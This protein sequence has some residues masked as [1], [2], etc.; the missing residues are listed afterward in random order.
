MEGTFVGV[1]VGGGF[2]TMDIVLAV[3]CVPP[4][5]VEVN[6]ID[7]VPPVPANVISSA[8]ISSL[9]FSILKLVACVPPTVKVG[10]TPTSSLRSAIFIPVAVPSGIPSVPK[11]P[12]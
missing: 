11:V 3:A 7:I 4:A 2:T 1:A 6:S 12:S 9:P 8:V 10:L 5:F